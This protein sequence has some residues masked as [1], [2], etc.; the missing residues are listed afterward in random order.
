MVST[1]RPPDVRQVLEPVVIEA[2]G[3]EAMGL[4][5]W[6]TAHASPA[7]DLP[8]G[9][10]VGIGVR[11]ARKTLHMGNDKWLRLTGALQAAWLVY[12]EPGKRFGQGGGSTPNRYWL[13][14]DKTLPNPNPH[15]PP[16][17]GSYFG[18]VQSEHPQPGYRHLVA[19]GDNSSQASVPNLGTS[20]D[21]VHVD[22]VFS[23]S[24]RK[25]DVPEELD[26]PAFLV[27][28]LR[29]VG[30]NAAV[31]RGV[32]PLLVA[33]VARHLANSGQWQR[34][35]GML[36]KL[37]S[38][39]KLHE[40]ALLNNLLRTDPTRELESFIDTA[41]TPALMPYD[42]LCELQDA[43]PNWY[44]QVRVEADRLCVD[45]GVS[46]SMALIREAALTIPVPD[47]QASERTS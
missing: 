10:V 27:E 47:A 38:Q 42:R 46:L 43:F 40:F 9:W 44:H 4:L 26:A 30:W 41:P 2:I 13:T 34:P 5:C 29:E 33:S 17:R 18:H 1:P 39:G 24:S 28:A 31:P 8:G 6:L 19:I 37:I 20:V 11:E 32:D 25:E 15:A 22:D 3:L 12:V 14:Y 21:A 7:L 36:N 45:R 23:S 16:P 35:A